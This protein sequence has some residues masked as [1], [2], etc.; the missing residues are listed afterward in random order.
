MPQQET[1]KTYGSICYKHPELGG[2]RRVKDRLCP[3]CFSDYRKRKKREQMEEWKRQVAEAE[4]LKAEAN[5]RQF[6]EA[7][8]IWVKYQNMDIVPR[9]TDEGEEGLNL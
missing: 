8:S 6:E 3:K 9:E 5:A 1:P 4:K 7:R 2:L